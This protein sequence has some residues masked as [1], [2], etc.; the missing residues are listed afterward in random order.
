MISVHEHACCPL[1]NRRLACVGI[2]PSVNNRY[3]TDQCCLMILMI[4]N[5]T[6]MRLIAYTMK[7]KSK[8]VYHR[9]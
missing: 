6:L 3:N 9:L 8:A 7:K 4:R 5:Q 1:F 2:D